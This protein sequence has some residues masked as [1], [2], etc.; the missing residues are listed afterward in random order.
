MKLGLVRP[1]LKTNR[2]INFWSCEFIEIVYQSG[3]HLHNQFK[4][5]LSNLSFRGP[6]LTL[7]HLGQ[8]Q[9][10]WPREFR[11]LVL[12]TSLNLIECA[13]LIHLTSG[14]LWLR[15]FQLEGSIMLNQIWVDEEFDTPPSSVIKGGT[16]NFFRNDS[17]SKLSSEKSD[18][19]LKCVRIGWAIWTSLELGVGV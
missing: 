6:I 5:C 9:L 1:E 12:P 13:A 3:S 18:L 16:K 11:Y 7:N 19:G 10:I 8:F 2:K 15:T 14:T 17:V 4:T